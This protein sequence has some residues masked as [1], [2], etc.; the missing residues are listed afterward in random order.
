MAEAWEQWHGEIID[1]QYRLRQFLGG[2]D[3]SAVFVAER[4]SNN[5]RVALKFIPAHP[6][7]AKQD[8]ARYDQ[9]S[10]LIHPNLLKFLG[11]GRSQLGN[12]SF[13]YVVSELAD[14]SLSQIVPQRALTAKE[15]GDMLRPLLSA[16]SYLHQNGYAHGHI[17]PA[18]IMAV[19]D[20]LKLSSDTVSPVGGATNSATNDLPEGERAGISKA[21][22]VWS[23][24]ATLVE[25]LTQR[26]AAWEET[27]HGEPLLR[28]KL[29]EPFREIARRALHRN[30]QRR[31][32]VAEIQDLL[33]PSP[34]KPVQPVAL[35]PE[36]SGSRRGL[37]IGITAAVVL[38]ALIGWTKLSSRAPQPQAT[39][40]APGLASA[41]SPEKDIPKPP[42]KTETHAVS[43]PQAAK[44]QTPRKLPEPQPETAPAAT[45]STTRPTPTP[46]N[47]APAQGA[48]TKGAVAHQ[49]L[50]DVP[51]SARNTITGRVRVTV[52]VS[53]DAKGNVTDVSL[54]S[55]GPSKYFARL[56]SEA[57]RQWKF[58]PPQA[59]GHD[60]AS[61]WLLRYGFGQ[62]DTIVS[63]TQLKP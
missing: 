23:L 30:P 12:S 36:P 59:N 22:D 51:R 29:P 27:A 37:V 4:T 13:L 60:V 49:V 56:A 3:H 47:A 63:P 48:S 55:P 18:N 42:A 25:V 31:P 17:V 38:V 62:T 57:S 8:L 35:P 20:Q 1:G 40:V 26:R 15:A 58:T 45:P 52:R 50:P 41:S 11:S 24:G 10:K 21:A 19:G 28:E 32:S 46:A 9:A 53:V 2:S 44:T 39:S 34:R 16:L 14:E 7:T 33:A 54:E 5:E 6:A 61:V 43:P